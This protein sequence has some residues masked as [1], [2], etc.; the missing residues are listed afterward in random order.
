MREAAGVAGASCD[1]PYPW[2]VRRGHKY[3]V[4]FDIIIITMDANP[5][6]SRESLPESRREVLTT[7]Q[8]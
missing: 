5:R 4:K 6:S 3:K 2:Q 8:G 7:T 1:H